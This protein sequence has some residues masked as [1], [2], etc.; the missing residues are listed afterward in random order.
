MVRDRVKYP[1]P[2]S[3]MHWRR[4]WISSMALPATS[5][6]RSDSG[7]DANQPK[8]SS[9]VIDRRSWMVFPA[10]FT[11]RASLRRRLPPQA[12]QVVRPL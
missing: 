9:T 12:W 5:L 6:S 8:S 1:R 7:A 3:S 2:T 11:Y 4:Y 10:T